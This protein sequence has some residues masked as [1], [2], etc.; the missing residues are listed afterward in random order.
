MLVARDAD[1]L[2]AVAA[3]LRA[4]AGIAVDVLPADLTDGAQ[5]AVVCDRVADALRPVH[6]LVNNAGFGAGKSFV[7][8]STDD[9]TAMVA[10]HITAVTRLTH[11][12]L[13]GMRERGAGLI[14]TVSSIAGLMPAASDS[15]YGATKAF[16]VAFME[17]L[18]A[19]H[20]DSQVRLLAVCP[21]MTRTDFHRRAGMD[22][23]SLPRIAW[24]TPER[25]VRDSLRAAARGVVVAVPSRRYALA[26]ALSR[27][28]PRRIAAV[29]TRRAAG[30][31]RPA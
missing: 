17:G 23:S 29:V 8:A 13:P 26:A 28:V 11:A 4:S 19:A 5:L 10:L 18:A 24:L 16:Q 25:V 9:L 20:V 1:R 22:V 15:L 7:R 31:R 3:E 27:A 30:G 14:I 2:E 6:T 21:G 12:A